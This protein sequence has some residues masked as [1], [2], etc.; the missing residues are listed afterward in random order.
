M[1][2]YCDIILWKIRKDMNDNNNGNT[3]DNESKLFQISAVIK[4]Y[5]N[6]NQNIK[7]VITITDY[8]G[9]KYQYKCVRIIYH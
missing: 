7:M 3:N 5:H 2:S 4:C 9:Y 8:I 6:G 1:A